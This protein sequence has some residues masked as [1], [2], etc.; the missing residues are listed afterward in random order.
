MLST[1]RTRPLRALL[2]S[3]CSTLSRKVLGQPGHIGEQHFNFSG[4]S[5]HTHLADNLPTDTPWP[6]AQ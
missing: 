2:A 3:T 5:S 6:M 4:G 1:V